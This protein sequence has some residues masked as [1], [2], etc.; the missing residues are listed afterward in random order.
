MTNATADARSAILGRLRA[1]MDTGP[2]P[3]LDTAVL[4]RRAWPA[5]ERVV[6]LRKGMEA[7]HT[8]FLDA[9]P[10]DWPAVVRA[11]CD[12]EG[13]KNLLF[14]PASEAG[15]AL[16][17]AWTPGGTQL[18]P[19]D[20]P[21][22]TFKE[23]LFTGVDAGFTDTVGGVAETGGLLLMPGP[24][25]PRLMSLVPP[26]HIALLRA[27]TIQN[28]FWSAVKSLGWGRRLPPNALMI[29]GPSKTADI[30]QT[31]AYG[32]HGPKRLIVVLVQDLS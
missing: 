3:G 4:E 20:R 24:A 14:G 32:V 12:R 31:L 10:A 18:L 29:S 30:E 22:E 19:Y 15:A 11:F 6:R 8:E 2:L 5:A 7:V 9:T 16:A 21:V 28:T 25:E 13:L 27:S 1:S 17:D 23:E 26:I